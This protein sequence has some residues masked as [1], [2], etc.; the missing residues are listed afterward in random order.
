MDPSRASEIMEGINIFRKDFGTSIIKP[1]GL[2]E[3]IRNDFET[4]AIDLVLDRFHLVFW[5]ICAKFQ[6]TELS[7][8]LMRSCK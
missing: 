7:I 1:A 6:L 8:D 4:I 2:D 3:M 5:P